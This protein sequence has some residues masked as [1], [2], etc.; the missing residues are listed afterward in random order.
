MARKRPRGA[1]RRGLLVSSA[2]VAEFSQPMNRYTAIGKPR[3][4]P[5]KPDSRCDGS[6]GVRLRLPE[7][8]ISTHTLTSSSS[9]ISNAN[10]APAHFVDSATPRTTSRNASSVSTAVSS[11]QAICTCAYFAIMSEIQ[12]PAM[13]TTAETAMMYPP[14]MTIAVVSAATGPNPRPMNVMNE[15][16]DGIDLVNWATVL[17]SSAIAMAAAM[18]VSGE[19]MPAATAISPMLK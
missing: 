9:P 2:R 10:S 12:Q 13:A 5:L 17:P 16:V 18:M 7:N 15:P 8:L 1:A 19:A 6:N 14:D 4:R 3:P 11:C